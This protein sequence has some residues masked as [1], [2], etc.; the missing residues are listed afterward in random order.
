MPHVRR[1]NDLI[2]WAR[3]EDFHSCMQARFEAQTTWN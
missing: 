3:P 1:N 2:I